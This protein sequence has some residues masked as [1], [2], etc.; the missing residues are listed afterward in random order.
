MKINSP[1]TKSGVSNG[2][3]IVTS[4]GLP[5]NDMCSREFDSRRSLLILSGGTNGKE[6]GFLHS[7]QSALTE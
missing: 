3:S 2:V 7:E 4:S 5:T 6:V 1:P